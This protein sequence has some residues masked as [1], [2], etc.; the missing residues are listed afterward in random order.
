MKKIL[1]L[2]MAVAMIAT[3]ATVIMAADEEKV[4]AKYT[5]DNGKDEGLEQVG[6]NATFAD[7]TVTLGADTYFKAPINLK[8]ATSVTVSLKVK[9]TGKTAWP[10]E[11]TSVEKH[12]YPKEHY[13]GA[14]LNADLTVERYAN[15]EEKNARPGNVFISGIGTEMVEIVIVYGAD[16]STKVSVNG[17]E[18]G[19]FT[20]P[21]GYD[22]S[23][24]NCV[25]ENPVLSIGHANWGEFSDGLVVDE[26]VVSATFASTSDEPSKEPSAPPTGFATIALAVAAIASGAYVVSKKNH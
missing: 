9:P 8:G 3:F 16:G 14:L 19:T 23:I 22:L 10:F 5:F 6:E 11:I 12:T 1:A 4:V 15:P 26:V 7:G 2:I 17:E 20:Q 13:L 18:K 25:G 24:A 21:D